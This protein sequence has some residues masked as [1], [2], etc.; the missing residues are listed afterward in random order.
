MGGRGRREC[1]GATRL[2]PQGAAVGLRPVGGTRP[3]FGQRTRARRG[4]SA[5]RRS[6][7]AGPWLAA[8][9]AAGRHSVEARAAG[10]AARAVAAARCSVSAAVGL[11]PLMAAVVGSALALLHTEPYDLKQ[12]SLVRLFG[13]GGQALRGGPA[14]VH[15]SFVLSLFLHAAGLPPVGA[16]QAR[17]NMY[18]CAAWPRPLALHIQPSALAM[19][20]LVGWRS[21]S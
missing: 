17:C 18:G 10:A 11:P 16:R 6:A 4:C 7:A 12:A 14:R 8:P 20:I 9:L 1:G 15:L 3:R 13:D 19:L 2:V 21:G 5:A